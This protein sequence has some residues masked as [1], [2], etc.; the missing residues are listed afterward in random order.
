MSWVVSLYIFNLSYI[1]KNY[2][3]YKIWKAGRQN[4]LFKMNKNQKT[5]SKR[6]HFRPFH[7]QNWYN[8]Y[9]WWYSH[10]SWK[11]LTVIRFHMPISELRS[12]KCEQGGKNWRICSRHFFG[13][14][15]A[16][17]SITNLL[18]PSMKFY[19]LL[20]HSKTFYTS[21]SF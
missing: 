5:P 16:K 15:K 14:G 2:I 12:K 9:R 19:F 13:C 3:L 1:E 10:R 21:I 11:Y 20:K 17:N 7:G 18:K 6:P 4:R 8:A